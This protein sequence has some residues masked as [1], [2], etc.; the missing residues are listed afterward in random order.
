[1]QREVLE[2]NQV[3]IYLA[4]I[5]IGWAAARLA[6][7]MA[8]WAEPLLWPALAL[9]LFATF[10]QT[11]LRQ[12]PSVFD[13]RRLL[14]ALVLGNFVVVPLL[15]ACLLPLAGA[16]AAVQLGVVLVLCVPCTDWFITFT[17]MAKGDTHA[18][19]AWTPLALLL[20]LALLPLYVWAML[21]AAM[22]NGL[23]QP[24]VL[25]AA[26]G[27]IVLPLLL[28]WLV[29]WQ[30]G[31]RRGLQAAV[32][33]MAWWPVP[34]LA[35][36][37]ALIAASQAQAL[38]A[39]PQVMLQ[40]ALVFVLYAALAGVLAWVLSHWLKLGRAQSMTV[41]MSLA[42]RNSFVM[43]PIAL[44]LGQGMELAA[45][46]IVLQSVVELLAIMGLLALLARWR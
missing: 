3:W 34:M 42:T 37:I 38:Q 40:P 19:I 9:L 16:H 33:R 17:Q 6:P 1:M 36:V 44:A 15:V 35:V 29:Q 2:K 23:W 7:G 32:D 13:K 21:D 45:S 10:A 18:A 30:A 8:Q 28:A 24:E 46:V 26:L 12:L 22:L 39:A 14:I 43:L 41:L 27:L 20:Q 4:A 5:A 11:P 31:Q 25:L